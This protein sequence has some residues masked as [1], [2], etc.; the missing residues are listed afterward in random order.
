MKPVETEA[1]NKHLIVAFGCLPIIIVCFYG[2]SELH[3]QHYM[4]LTHQLL[5]LFFSTNH[6]NTNYFPKI[7]RSETSVVPEIGPSSSKQQQHLPHCCG[8]GESKLLCHVSRQ[9]AFQIVMSVR[10]CGADVCVWCVVCVCVWCV[11]CVC[12]L[13]GWDLWDTLSFPRFAITPAVH[14]DSFTRCDDK[15]S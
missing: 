12:G 14:A 7:G 2:L 13:G 3:E 4:Q 9:T 6:N 5:S 8:I 1:N 10:Q 15:Q 11:W